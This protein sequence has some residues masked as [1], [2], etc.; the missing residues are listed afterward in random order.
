MTIVTYVARVSTTTADTFGVLAAAA[1]QGSFFHVN[2]YGRPQD[3][4]G[5]AVASTRPS[6]S[7]FQLCPRVVGECQLRSIHSAV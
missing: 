7:P 2:G 4:L 6:G 5:M 1:A 3:E